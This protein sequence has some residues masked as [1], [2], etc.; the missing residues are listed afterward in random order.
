MKKLILIF[1][2][3]PEVS[4]LIV[5]EFMPN[6]EGP[7][8]DLEWIELYNSFNYSINLDN[9]FLNGK[10][11]Q[12]I[13]LNPKETLII[14]RQLLDKD[15]N[16]FSLEKQY[17][18]K[19][20]ILDEEDNFKAIES[21]FTLKNEDGTLNLT[22][23]SYT[24]FISY[25]KSQEGFS[26]VKKDLNSEFIIS[27]I[28]NGEPGKFNTLEIK[29][30]PLP[31]N[32]K[33]QPTNLEII[34]FLPNPEG[35][36]DDKP[37]NGEW[38]IIKN[39][40]ELM[41]TEGFYFEDSANG[42]LLISSTNVDGNIILQPGAILKIYRNGQDFS[43]NNNGDVLKLKSKDNQL[44]DLVSYTYSTEGISWIKL[45]SSWVLNENFEA[46]EKETENYIKIEKIY[47]KTYFNSLVYIKLNIYYKNSINGENDIV[48]HIENL[49]E[50]IK[51]QLYSKNINYSMLLPIKIPSNCN[52]DFNEGNYFITASGIS[53]FDKKRIFVESDE[54]CN[55][56]IIKTAL[57]EKKE[58]AAIKTTTNT[59]SL[60]EKPEL[61]EEKENIINEKKPVYTAKE[62]QIRSY[63][64]VLFVALLIL[65]AGAVIYGK[66]ENTHKDNLGSSWSPKRP[67][68]K[69][70]RYDFGEYRED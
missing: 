17:G 64:V 34:E 4:A 66:W 35:P 16:N 62:T 59:I 43:L 2:L 54:K 20:N 42:R 50:K 38:I 44:I 53:T 55:Q 15:N 65:I 52:N 33:S 31:N 23:L 48:L 58:E 13:N 60:P 24:I 6:P 22:N 26:F 47:G 69:D 19:N 29:E 27:N 30:N 51:L 36:D 67:R 57:K 9:F 61:N 41:E 7:D 49:T 8:E 1:L 11:L 18:N 32:T 3:I 40:G 70:Y 56:D 10:K 5:T 28:K 46:E 25:G 21:S 63:A 45:N 37:P 12:S 68:R 14:A 39:N